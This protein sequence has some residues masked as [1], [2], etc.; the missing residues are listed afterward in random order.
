MWLR[1]IFPRIEK[2]LAT[3]IKSKKKLIST[4]QLNYEKREEK[5]Y[6]IEKIHSLN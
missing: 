2:R 5:K 1:E 6:A 3:T 4:N